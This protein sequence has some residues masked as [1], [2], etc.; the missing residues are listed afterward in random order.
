[1][2]TQQRIYID[3]ILDCKVKLLKP[4]IEETLSLDL[5]KK[6]DTEVTTNVENPVSAKEEL[7]RPGASSSFDAHTFEKCPVC[8]ESFKDPVPFLRRELHLLEHFEADVRPLLPT[9]KPPFKCPAPCTGPP[10]DQERHALLHVG[11]E[12]G[13]FARLIGKHQKVSLE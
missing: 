12:H 1:M 5:V 8:Y 4:K 10:L 7:T 13:E 3:I 2:R 9:S 6:E 11:L